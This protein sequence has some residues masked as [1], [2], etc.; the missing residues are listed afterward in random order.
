[1]KNDS[2]T[3]VCEEVEVI[4]VQFPSVRLLIIQE[5]VGGVVDV[6]LEKLAPRC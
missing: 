4:R 5:D 1:V 3:E 2:F 6:V